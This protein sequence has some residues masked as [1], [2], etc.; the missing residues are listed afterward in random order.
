[1]W[2]VV[3]YILA[4]IGVIFVGLF[5]YLMV[6]DCIEEGRRLLKRDEEETKNTH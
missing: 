6:V 2:N 5:F 1:M 3:S 4:G